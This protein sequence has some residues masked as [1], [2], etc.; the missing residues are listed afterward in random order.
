MDSRGDAEP[1]TCRGHPALEQRRFAAAM[2]CL[3]ATHHAG[4]PSR[5]VTGGAERT[6][7]VRM[8]LLDSPVSGELRSTPNGGADVRIPS[9][10]PR[11]VARALGAVGTRTPDRSR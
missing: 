2:E 7:P 9:E 6:A 5:T 4:S 11:S 3:R 8:T 1:R 10:T